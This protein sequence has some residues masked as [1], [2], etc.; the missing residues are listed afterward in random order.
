MMFVEAFVPKGALTDDQLDRLA[1][2]L[3]FR[4][5]HGADAE[6]VDPGV[7]DFLESLTN[8]VIH[9][10]DVWI[11]GGRRLGP[12]RPPRYVVRV[13]VPGP[14]RR[15][16]GDH[17]VTRIFEAISRVDSAPDR[18]ESEPVAEVHVLGVPNGG[19]GVYGRVVDESALTELIDAAKEGVTNVPAGMAVDPTCGAIVPLEGE[20]AVTADVDGTVYA[21][22]CPGCR[23]HYLKKREESQVA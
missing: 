13:H 19:Y 15:A 20:R 6:Q 5:V 14:W 7:L 18:L 16:L 2:E 4:G 10:A 21:F 11:G 8:V 1:Q 23:R 9:Q 17:L 12:G 3:T 22:C